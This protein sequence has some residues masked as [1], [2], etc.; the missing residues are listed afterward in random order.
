MDNGGR[1]VIEKTALSS[2]GLDDVRAIALAGGHGG[3]LLR[4]LGDDAAKWAAA[5]CAIAKKQGHDI[6][7]G[8]MIGWFA[9]AIE[10]SSDCRRGG[11]GMPVPR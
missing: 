5:F 8:W 9:N 10:H 3:D 11:G 2:D 7:E 6:D 1:T 4:A